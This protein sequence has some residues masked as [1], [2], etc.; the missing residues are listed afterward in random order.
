MTTITALTA[1]SIKTAAFWPVTSGATIA[2][3]SQQTTTSYQ[4]LLSNG[5][6]LHYVGTGFTYS[7]SPAVP[8]GGTYTTIEL[9]NTGLTVIGLLDGAAGALA[10]IMTGDPSLAVLSGNDTL[11]GG[12]GNDILKA[13]DGDDVIFD[14][15]GT[16]T[17]I[18]GGNGNDLIIIGGLFTSGTIA[19][20]AG[21]ADTLVAGQSNLSLLT[22]TGLE[23]LHTNF[24]A[25]MA[26]AAQ[27]EEFDTIR[28]DQAHTVEAVTLVV[29]A[30]GA[31]TALDLAGALGLRAVNL[32]GSDDAE[33]IT[34]GSG[35]D[36]IS[37]GAGDDSVSGGDGADT[38]EGLGGNDTL[39]G[40]ADADRL[41]GGAGSDSLDGG[42]GSDVIIDNAGDA[43]GF[44]GTSF[45]EGGLRNDAII[46]GAAKFADGTINGGD[47]TDTLFAEGDFHALTLTGLEVL[48]TGFGAIIATAAQLEVFD[49]IR[50]DG[51]HLTDRPTINLFATGAVASID[52]ADELNSD[53]PRGVNL[54]GSSDAENIT[55]GEG[56]DSIFAG[57]GDDT[58]DA[59]RGNDTIGGDGGVNTISFVTA[60]WDISIDLSGFAHAGANGSDILSNF[61]NA[62]GGSGN[63]VINGTIIANRLE[64]GE[65]NDLIDGD[66]Q[67]DQAGGNDS[68]FGGA[69]DDVIIDKYGSVAQIFGGTGSDR[70]SLA[71]D[72]VLIS[73]TSGVVDGG[74]DANGLDDDILI[75]S[76]ASNNLNAL[77][78]TGFE[79]LFAGSTEVFGT[80]VDFAAFKRIAFN[81][82]F[83]LNPI[84]LTLLASG[85]TTVVDL[86]AALTAGAASSAR[87]TGTGDSE[88]IF[89]GTGN[90]SVSGGL[91]DDTLG[92]GAGNDTLSGG[93]G[94]DTFRFNA[95][96]FGSD[97]ITDFTRT[98]QAAGAHDVIDLG[99]LNLTFAD[100]TLSVLSGTTTITFTGHAGDQI[101]LS[102]TSGLIA[103]DFN[104]QGPGPRNF[105]GNAQGNTADA[106]A[107]VLTGFVGGTIADLQDGFG[108][109]FFGNGGADSILAGAGNDTV[110]GGNGPDTL[111]GG[112]GDDTI[113]GGVG[114]DLLFGGEG[115]NTV[116]YATQGA[117]VRVNLSLAVIVAS[118]AG[119]NDT[120]QGFANVIGTDFDDLISGDAANNRLE[121]GAGRDTL[122]GGAGDDTLK[123]GAGA[124][125]LSDSTGIVSID[126]GADND[127]IIIR[128]ASTGTIDGG[129]GTDSL[130]VGPSTGETSTSLNGFTI[131]QIE[132]LDAGAGLVAA[133]AAQFEAFD[134]IR[135]NDIAEAGRVRLSLLASGSP[136]TLDL[137][138]E[139]N[140][141]SV[142][143]AVDLFGSGDDEVLTLGAGNDTASGNDGNDSLFGGAGQD[144]LLGESGND[145]LVGLTGNDTLVGGLGNDSFSGGDNDD[146]IV[147]FAGTTTQISG[148]NG[149]DVIRLGGNVFASGIIGGGSGNDTLNT[150]SANDL[151]GLTLSL[152][153]VLETGTGKVTAKANQFAGFSI[154]R[155]DGVVPTAFV[156]LDLKSTG[157]NQT[158]NLAAALAAG[159]GPRGVVLT[160]SSDNETLTTGVGDDTLNGNGGNDVLRGGDGNDAI[161][162]SV[163]TTVSMDGGL[164]DDILL[165]GTTPFASGKVEGGD[166]TD[167]LRVI[168]DVSKLTIANVE[169]LEAPG[170]VLAFAGQ[171]EAFDTIRVAAGLPTAR[172]ALTLVATGGPMV[173][174]LTDELNGTD[175][176]QGVILTGSADNETLITGEGADIVTGGGGVNLMISAGGDDS[177]TATGQDSV[178]AGTGNDTINVVFG[179]SPAGSLNGGDGVDTLITATKSL[180]QASLLGLEVLQTQEGG[181]VTARAA[182]FEAF[183]TIRSGDGSVAERLTTVN[184]ILAASGASTV[185]DLASE[186]NS[187]GGPRGVVLN[188]SADAER[189]TTGG[190]ADLINGQGGNDTIFA[191]F[192]DDTLFLKIGN[193]IRANGGGDNDR[194]VIVGTGVFIGATGVLNGGD[195]IDTLEGDGR[196]IT[197]LQFSLIET[198]TTGSSG[199]FATAG[200][201]EK[202]NTIQ[203]A[204]L[205]PTG[206]AVVSLVSNGASAVLDLAGELTS[207]GVRGIN[208]TATAADETITTADGNDTLILGGGA[209]TANTAGGNDT[210]TDT[211]GAT[212]TIDAGLGNDAIII[213]H[214]VFTSGS[215]AGND[216]SD[217][218]SAEGVNLSLLT[219]SGLEVL[220]VG[221]GLQATASQ[222]QKFAVI[223]FGGGLAAINSVH[224]DLVGQGRPSVLDL[225]DQLLAGGRRAVALIGTQDNEALTTGTRDDSIDGGAGRDRI[226]AG[227]GNDVLLGGAGVDSLF[228]QQGN[229]TL[230]GGDDADQLTGGAGADSFWLQNTAP[231]GPDTIADF[232]SGTD[233]ILIDR[234]DFGNFDFGGSVSVANWFRITTNGQAKDLDDRFI[235]S[236]T[237]GDLFFDADGKGA[238]SAFV[239]ANLGVS[240]ANVARTLLASD[241]LVETDISF[242][243]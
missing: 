78:V 131:S 79:S 204:S 217:A 51:A 26:T 107:G 74:E 175:G 43:Q 186:L 158:L 99:G 192:G 84:K 89:T 117:A 123:G 183:D 180:T 42:D 149:D 13:R 115:I 197:G 229:D 235:Y 71:Q 23:V 203:A 224:L 38:I 212:L 29:A 162:D 12:A 65:G 241:F 124:D 62:I 194:F 132:V 121:G 88:A 16:A 128:G 52:L 82:V 18:D 59:G 142:G 80:A 90:D 146:L 113:I 173:L 210:I 28:M 86:A 196:S 211:E 144:Q 22:L 200:Q 140:G 230:G 15:V 225:S 27:F 102:N 157:V 167:L 228:G 17:Q 237:T 73:P 63:D 119:S 137:A 141:G 98:A 104:F 5:F 163:G 35:T 72:N 66:R 112:A 64:G 152:L 227:A 114:S 76:A 223:R 21:G 168:G 199:V 243:F 240:S 37:A 156:T 155:Q 232:L 151:S 143:R 10:A 122:F 169:I 55:T 209:D 8:T 213:N 161:S 91:G 83:P 148:D 179:N 218:L 105:I 57:D 69:G 93:L 14:T 97:L 46:I 54:N 188:G 147:D 165:L 60:T 24:G 216:G 145:F 201:L 166:G 2:S 75:L 4:V 32:T 95:F 189:I 6:S 139:L 49:T 236:S 184:L 106:G 221:T 67:N 85:E 50:F 33:N 219:L 39:R 231:A 111:N 133:S 81:D 30:S 138:A 134:L 108:D 116:S 118:G 214:A 233:R 215:I 45:I 100:L 25:T 87:I 234:T 96:G 195:G 41:D 190:G 70:I 101:V 239:V 135:V 153:E 136:T 77:N 164:G 103:S 222:L 130:S 126:A 159:G 176:P 160:G 181:T 220:N 191:G 129:D 125:A 20:G 226:N 208:L 61:Q 44:G 58:V 171:L 127:R 11:T 94:V 205:Q 170:S 150:G 19:G 109:H 242:D 193:F 172:V 182:Q 36:S 40:G 154:I 68:L 47:G 3:V 238:A 187:G 178:D 202:F 110:E 120:L 56:A 48:Q 34:T 174:D 207:G 177:I 198:L 185:V 206:T 53:G 1:S 31:A 92:A 7:G 9:L